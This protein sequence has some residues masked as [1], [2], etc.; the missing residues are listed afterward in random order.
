MR[1][2]KKNT[3][4]IRNDDFTSILDES[5]W[6]SFID[7]IKPLV[8]V[9]LVLL[10]IGG[11]VYGGA[12]LFS[13]NRDNSMSLSTSTAS[14]GDKGVTDLAKCVNDSISANP[15]P[16][17]NDPQFY[18]KLISNYDKQ[19]SCYDKYPNTDRTNKSHLAKL[20]QGA[21]RARDE[22]GTSTSNINN[23]NSSTAGSGGQDANSTTQQ[24]SFNP[25][26]CDSYKNEYDRLKAISDQLN[27]SIQ[28][29]NSPSQASIDELKKA[30]DKQNKSYSDF[31]KCKA[32]SYQ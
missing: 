16:E 28:K 20:R 29:Q 15:T 1:L 8:K 14:T 30:F 3:T 12:L 10:V 21:I 6:E 19:I 27:D 31:Q 26:A 17:T 4:P 22:A 25:N 18:D 11:L 2:Q 24:S 32:E 13:G 23:T 9:V 5:P 7:K